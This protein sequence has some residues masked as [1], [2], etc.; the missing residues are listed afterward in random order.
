M[1]HHL[2]SKHAPNPPPRLSHAAGRH[3]SAGLADLRARAFQ[4]LASHMDIGWDLDGTLINHQAA[5]A[6]QRFIMA[7]PHIR[8]VLVTFRTKRQGA[9][10]GLLA[11]YAS[12][13][14]AAHFDRVLH[15]PE[16]LCA[17]LSEDTA[18]RR[19]GRWP[20]LPPLPLPWRRAADAV[21]RTWKGHI[22]RQEGI[23]AL[24]DDLTSLVAEGCRRHGVELFHP[25]DFLA[26]A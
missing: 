20:S 7:T 21:H 11:G 5:P 14:G 3:G 22:C 8:H 23:T 1:A 19:G 25:S 2:A 18:A 15:L 9:P 16:E 26:G 12:G 10:W 17:G 6:L 4:R 24:V 13:I